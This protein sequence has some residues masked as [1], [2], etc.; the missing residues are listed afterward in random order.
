MGPD[1]S[2]GAGQPPEGQGQGLLP[3]KNPFEVGCGVKGI[4]GHSTNLVILQ[5]QVLQ[6][7]WE[8]PGDL[9]ELIPGNV[10][11]LQG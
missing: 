1:P 4:G 2:A 9:R 10:E 8:P 6:R 5:V 7:L 11:Q 3:E